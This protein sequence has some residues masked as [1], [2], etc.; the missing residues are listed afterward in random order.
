MPPKEDE[1][2]VTVKVVKKERKL[3]VFEGTEGAKGF[4]IWKEDALS[5]IE[6]LGYTGKEAAKHVYD[7][8]SADCKREIKLAQGES[9]KESAEELLK[10]LASIYGDKRSINQRRTA[11][12]DCKQREDENILDYSHRL[13]SAIEAVEELDKEVVGAVRTKMLKDQFAEKVRDRNLRWEL[14]K[15][16]DEADIKEFRDLRQVA[17]DWSDELGDPDESRKSSSRRP[18]RAEEQLPVA[19]GGSN[20]RPELENRFQKIETQLGQHSSALSTILQ[21]QQE[22]LNQLK[23]VKLGS[24]RRGDGGR[25][26]HCYNCGEPGHIRR[27]CPHK[28]TKQGNGPSPANP[29]AQLGGK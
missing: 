12:Y 13:L 15:R 2:K 21:Q 24:G 20:F 19:T 1:G 28:T 11:F 10:A 14:K 29:G 9:A 16:K 22:I 3:K 5:A 27:D 6:S 18:A 7:Y 23:E 17:L 26:Y 25:H 4:R 8:L